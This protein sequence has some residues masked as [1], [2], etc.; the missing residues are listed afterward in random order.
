MKTQSSN[1]PLDVISNPATSRQH[2]DSSQRGRTCTSIFKYWLL[3]VSA[4]ALTLASA[5]PAMATRNHAR[6]I[7]YTPWHDINTCTDSGTPAD[8]NVSDWRGSTHYWCHAHEEKYSNYCIPGY[9]S[10]CHASHHRSWP[11]INSPDQPDPDGASSGPPNPPRPGAPGTT[12]YL[13]ETWI[14]NQQ[15][16]QVVVSLDKTSFLQIDLNELSSTN[17]QVI[18]RADLSATGGLAG[19]V[20][21]TGFF[22]DNQ[23]PQVRLSLT[24]A[25]EKLRTTMTNNANGTVVVKFVNQPSWTLPYNEDEFETELE[26]STAVSPRMTGD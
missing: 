7:L 14:P 26:G 16:D 4:A 6:C 20:I 5:V 1:H 18:S 3:G 2:N 11:C 13:W 9:G 15:G 22:D 23:Q 17:P 12:G 24:G 10:S 21:L 25:F 8:I 19:S